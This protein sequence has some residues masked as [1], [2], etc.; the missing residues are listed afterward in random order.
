MAEDVFMSL[1]PRSNTVES[2]PLRV[3]QSSGVSYDPDIKFTTTA[4]NEGKKHFQ[5]NSGDGDSFTVTVMLNMADTVVVTKEFYDDLDENEKSKF[6]ITMD[7]PYD[8]N[9][10]SLIKVLDYFIREGVPFYVYTRAVGINDKELWLVTA[11]KSRVQTH[12]VVTITP[13][14]GGEYESAFV[15]WELTFTKYNELNLSTFNNDNAGVTKAI[16]NYNKKKNAKKTTKKNTAKTKTTIYQK[17]AKCDYKKLVYSKTKKTTSCIKTMQEILYKDGSLKGKKATVVDGWF[18]D[19]TKA[20]VK[21]YQKKYAKRDGLKQNGKVDKNT[22]NSLCG[23][24]GKTKVLK[25]NTNTNKVYATKEAAL[26]AIP[27]ANNT[28]S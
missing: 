28:I 6:N 12:D 21:A 10:D 19:K 2:M 4:L 3:V 24:V 7:G 8:V 22:F 18:G 5:N 14:T 26:N 17:L 25:S 11:N 20:A 16:K 15:E 27:K 13:A 23:Q 9:T 1:L